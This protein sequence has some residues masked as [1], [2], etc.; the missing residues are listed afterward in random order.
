MIE[1]TK[2]QEQV[3][4]AEDAYE[5]AFDDLQDAKRVLQQ[6]GQSI[7]EFMIQTLGG[8]AVEKLKLTIQCGVDPVADGISIKG[9]EAGKVDE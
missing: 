7:G 8:K 4:V 9:V 2:L 3:K 5:N 6:H 1:N